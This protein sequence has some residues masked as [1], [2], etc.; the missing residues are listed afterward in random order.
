MRQ[1][2]DCQIGIFLKIV[3]CRLMVA[4]CSE[5]AAEQG[6]QSAVRLGLLARV[7]YCNLGAGPQRRA[8]VPQEAIGLGDFMVH[9]DE[10]GEID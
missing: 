6:R 10:K 4:D 2:E 9:V 7:D 8:Q 3:E 5:F 1:P